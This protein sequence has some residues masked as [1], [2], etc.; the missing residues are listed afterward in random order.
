LRA[1]G[2]WLGHR[3]RNWRILT[4]TDQEGEATA[5]T[6]AKEC[7]DQREDDRS[8]NYGY[9]GWMKDA[10]PPVDENRRYGESQR[11]IRH[12]QQANRALDTQPDDQ[13]TDDEGERTKDEDHSSKQ[14]LCAL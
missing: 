3:R 5:N 10:R 6:H 13:E 1:I 8:D 9:A 12:V 11:D 14:E 4:S 2:V 7:L